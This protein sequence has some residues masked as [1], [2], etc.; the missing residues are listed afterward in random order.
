MSAQ[1]SKL[2][3]ESGVIGSCMVWV[4]WAILVVSVKYVVFS[5]SVEVQDIVVV[6]VV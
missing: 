1:V 3:C 2:Y 5:G 4:D 6:G